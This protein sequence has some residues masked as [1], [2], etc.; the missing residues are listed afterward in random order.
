VGGPSESS[1][2]EEIGLMSWHFA[3]SFFRLFSTCVPPYVLVWE[4]VPGS[5]GPTLVPLFLRG[6]GAPLSFFYF[7]GLD[8]RGR[9]SGGLFSFELF[10][11]VRAALGWFLCDA[12]LEMGCSTID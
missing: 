4:S 3:S 12:P 1:C 10:V 11:K 6:P 9:R 8:P 2:G 7:C 5:G